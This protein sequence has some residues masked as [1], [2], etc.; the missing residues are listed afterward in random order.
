[1]TDIHVLAAGPVLDRLVAEE[2]MGW[3]THFRLKPGERPAHEGEEHFRDP[4]NSTLYL[5]DQWCPSS[6][7][8]QS[9]KVLAELLSEHW[10]CEVTITISRGSPED[11]KTYDVLIRQG[12][13]EGR[14]SVEYSMELAICKAAVEFVR[15]R[16]RSR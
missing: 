9:Q 13:D 1:M 2:V 5:P 16:A 6:D 3:D 8:E 7:S 11:D 10:D 14:A 12:P 15:S 4:V